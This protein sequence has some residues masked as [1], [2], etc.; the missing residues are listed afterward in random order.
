MIFDSDAT[1]GAGLSLWPTRL[2]PA[3]FRRDQLHP[4]RRTRTPDHAESSAL[5]ACIFMRWSGILIRYLEGRPEAA[6]T[7]N[8]AS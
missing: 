7:G 5:V 8:S 4:R 6:A 2:R 1:R 3:G